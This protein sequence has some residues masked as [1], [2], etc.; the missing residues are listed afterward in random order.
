M[1]LSIQVPRVGLVIRASGKLRHSYTMKVEKEREKRKKKR[2]KS[3][4]LT[5]GEGGRCQTQR[6]ALFISSLIAAP[7]P[8]TMGRLFFSRPHL[9]AVVHFS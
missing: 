8:D 5:S 9:P 1:T 2:R 7:S 6:V 3:T 4:T